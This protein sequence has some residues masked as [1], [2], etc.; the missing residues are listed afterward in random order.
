MQWKG[1]NKTAL[2]S[3]AA[4]WSS[5]AAVNPVAL[6]AE[7]RTPVSLVS[8]FF[9]LRICVLQS[10][11]P[12]YWVS[13]CLFFCCSRV[14]IWVHV[15]GPLRGKMPMV[16]FKKLNPDNECLA[17]QWFKIKMYVDYIILLSLPLH[18]CGVE[19]NLWER[20]LQ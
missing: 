14:C 12:I 16:R 13:F 2:L 19:I 6:K 18:F 1:L 7:G 20:T 5:A 8:R 11:T 3:A 10:V 15:R 17:C 4:W 9:F